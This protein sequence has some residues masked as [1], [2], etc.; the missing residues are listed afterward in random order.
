VARGLLSTAA[1]EDFELALR[2]WRARSGGGGALALV[3]PQLWG[4]EPS[5]AQTRLRA[6]DQRA[7][8]RGMRLTHFV[9]RRLNAD[10]SVATVPGPWDGLYL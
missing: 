6:G 3:R 5:L 1:L 10:R 2:V 9:F 7:G 4:P 8:F